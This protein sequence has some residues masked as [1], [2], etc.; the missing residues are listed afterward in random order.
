MCSLYLSSFI[1]RTCFGTTRCVS[2]PTILM[3]IFSPICQKDLK[4]KPTLT[5]FHTVEIS[6]CLHKVKYIFMISCKMYKIYYNSLINLWLKLRCK[7][8]ANAINVKLS[9][10]LDAN[11]RTGNYKL[12]VNLFS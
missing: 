3:K 5:Q 4:L 10:Q 8:T 7:A 1:C 11:H 6:P 9:Y 12:S 2:M